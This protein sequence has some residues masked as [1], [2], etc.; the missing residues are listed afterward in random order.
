MPLNVQ[1]AGSH[2]GRPSQG[3]S[4]LDLVSLTPHLQR[5]GGRGQAGNEAAAPAKATVLPLRAKRHRSTARS[6]AG[7]SQGMQQLLVV[8]STPCQAQHGAGS[9][10]DPVHVTSSSAPER[11]CGSCACFHQS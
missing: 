1:A 2:K 9:C 7:G 8:V 11:G 10:C 4:G 3:V 6:M 5:S